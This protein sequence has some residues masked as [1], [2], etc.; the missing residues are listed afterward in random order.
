MALNGTFL[1]DDNRVDEFCGFV[2]DLTGRFPV[3]QIEIDGPWPPY[4]FATL[5]KL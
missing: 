4:S 1:V 2:K 3:L 5:E